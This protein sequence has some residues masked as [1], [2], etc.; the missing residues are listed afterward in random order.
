M[1][2]KNIKGSRKN[3]INNK[4]N[5]D[6]NPRKKN[7]LNED[8]I[9]YDIYSNI[10]D[11]NLQPNNN[12]M[13]K[14]KYIEQLESKIE[15]QGKAISELNKYKYLCEKRLRQL[16]PNEILPVTIE[17]LNNNE[18]IFN[19]NKKNNINS[20]NKDIQKKYELLNEKFQ[21]LLN[22]YNDI[23][24]NN[25]MNDISCATINVGNINEKY[26]ILKEKYKKI[27]EENNKIIEVLKEETKACEMQKNIIDILQQAIESD[28]CKN[29]ELKKYI[30]VDN[31]IDFTQ[32]KMESEQYRKEL[33]LSQALVN[34]LKSEIEQLNKEKEQIKINNNFY[35]NNN[36]N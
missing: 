19:L 28:I 27:K 29:N 12:S 31:I 16:N 20:Y 33:I 35:N 7:E 30:S 3:P 18:N 6:Y 17:S 13:N 5:I 8:N 9:E 10:K 14:E 24:K 25:N 21:K 23:I 2:R 26:K 4:N 36:E 11:D 22:D 1:T 32:L 34:S 15:Q